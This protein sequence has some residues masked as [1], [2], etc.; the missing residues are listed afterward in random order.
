MH[1]RNLY[2]PIAH[3]AVEVSHSLPFPD[4]GNEIYGLRITSTRHEGNPVLFYTPSKAFRTNTLNH[5]FL[6]ASHCPN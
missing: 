2:L 4:R 3:I 5:S 6:Q 1:L